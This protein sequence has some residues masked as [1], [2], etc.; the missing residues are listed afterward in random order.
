MKNPLPGFVQDFLAV[1]VVYRCPLSQSSTWQSIREESERL[2]LAI[3]LMIY[4]N[5]PVAQAIPTTS[6]KIYYQ[7]NELNAGVSKAYNEGFQLAQRLSKK[8]LLLLDQ[9]SSLPAGWIELY[10]EAA[11]YDNQNL[12]AP[13]VHCGDEIISPFNYWLCVGRS[14]KTMSTGTKSLKNSYA[15]NSGLLVPTQL[16]EK[17]GGYDELVRLDFSDFVFMHKLKKVKAQLRVIDLHL[18]SQLSSHQYEERE[19]VQ[20][21]FYLYCIGSRRF[22]HYTHQP[23]SHFLTALFRALKLGARYQTFEFIKISLRA[24]AIA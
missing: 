23:F 9:D 6:N 21:R 18:E 7:H 24:W 20:E 16:F 17:V 15:I 3:D 22:A 2:G 4:D 1:L 12:I 11:Q 14:P 13:I 19:K 8:W 10:A 5:S